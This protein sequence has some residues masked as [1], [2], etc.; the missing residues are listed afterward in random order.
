MKRGI[1]ILIG[2]LVI[3]LVAGVLFWFYIQE[4]CCQIPNLEAKQCLSSGGEIKSELCGCEGGKDFYNNCEVGACSCASLIK[5]SVKICDCGEG[6]CFD[7]STC[8]NQAD[9]YGTQTLP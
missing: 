4:S 6:K 5:H 2:I 3:T 8:R 9:F 7:G 1:W